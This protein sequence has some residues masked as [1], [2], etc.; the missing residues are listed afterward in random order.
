MYTRYK[1]RGVQPYVKANPLFTPYDISVLLDVS[2]PWRKLWRT[3]FATDSV[4]FIRLTAQGVDKERRVRDACSGWL[5]FAM[6]DLVG[7]C[8]QPER[9][10]AIWKGILG[11]IGL[12]HPERAC[13][14]RKGI[15]V[16]LQGHLG[17]K[18]Y[19]RQKRTTSP[20]KGIHG[21]KGNLWPKRA[22]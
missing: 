10:F 1:L 4:R 11:L 3:V 19:L 6:P 2:S 5:L 16:L 22:L 13:L 7:C 18:G 21:P 8:L 12:S 17:P 9:E 20:R 14:A 15:L